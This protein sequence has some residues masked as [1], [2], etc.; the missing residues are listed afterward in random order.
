MADNNTI[1]NGISSLP[2]KSFM[3]V[4]PTLHYSHSH[5]HAMWGITVFVFVIV[6]YFWN[7][8]QIGGPVSID[9]MELADTSLFRLGQ[10]V[11]RPISIYEYPWHIIVLGTLMGILAVAPVLVSQ[12]YSFRYSLPLV[13]SIFFIGQLYLFSGFVLVSCL[14]AACRP[15]RFRSR[16][17]AIALCM[18]PQ[19]IYWA[20][21]GGYPTADPVR[22]GFSFAPWIY[23]WLAALALAGLVLGIGHFTRYRPGLIGL[24]SLVFLGTA[25]GVFQKHIGFSEMDYQRYVA[26]NNPEDAPEFHEQSLSATL[27]RV[28]EDESLRSYLKGQFYPTDEPILLRQKLKEEIQSLLLLDRWP[29]WFGRKMPDELKYQTK[30]R[31]LRYEYDQFINR[32]P[33]SKRIPIALYFRSLLSEY[34]PDTRAIASKEIL[35]FYKDYPFPENLLGWQELFEQYPQSPESL[36]ARWRIAMHAAGKGNFEKANEYCQVAL[37]MIREQLDRFPG[38]GITEQSDSIFAAFQKPSPT[39]M[40]PFKLRELQMRFRK[41]QI[42][43]SKE[44][45]GDTPQ[46]QQNLAQFVLLNPYSADYANRLEDLFKSMPQEDGLRDNILL[47]KAMLEIDPLRRCQLL[48]EV[49][50]QYPDRDAGIQAQY[51]LGLLK[52]QMWKKPETSDETKKQLAAEALALLSAFA[53][54]YPDSPYTEQAKAL[55]ETL[56]KLE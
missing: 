5:V 45:R 25:F 47:E 13:L 18:A 38:P 23:A 32:W 9:P 52:V 22:W 14:A 43:I 30:R 29:E 40:T 16:I 37:A 4:G 31:A 54:K 27:D 50:K 8:I 48:N 7:Q 21:W 35:R 49:V 3:T 39:V 11:V 53:E 44:N 1:P 20:V 28:L 26:G 24:V 12:L 36:E 17:V 19:L 15:L 2:V 51:E 10:I 46:A 56:P 41:L 33:N 34:H 6:C 42:R 55:L